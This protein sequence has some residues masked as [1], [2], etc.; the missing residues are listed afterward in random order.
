MI[1]LHTINCLAGLI[2]VAEAMNKLHRTAPC[3]PGLT[4]HL[5]IVAI[6]KACAWLLLG[7]GGGAF[8]FAP[9]FAILQPTGIAPTS[10]AETAIVLGFA[11]LIIRTRVKEG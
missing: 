6:L 10:L 1:L 5:R 2:V 9:V 7:F 4:A 3:A 11:I 8:L